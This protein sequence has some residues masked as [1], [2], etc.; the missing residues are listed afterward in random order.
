MRGGLVG[1]G[2]VL[3]APIGSPPAPASMCGMRDGLGAPRRVR[4]T[5]S[6]VGNAG[7][8]RRLIYGP[9]LRGPAAQRLGGPRTAHR[10]RSALQMHVWLA[11]PDQVLAQVRDVP[12]GTVAVLDGDELDPAYALRCG[13]EREAV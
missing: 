4:R 11:A 7:W 3:G 1:V 2:E 8:A 10:R 5:R 6:H 13:D 9:S 12:T